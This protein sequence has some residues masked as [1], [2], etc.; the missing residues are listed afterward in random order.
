[1]II[2]ARNNLLIDINRM[3]INFKN[4]IIFIFAL[5]FFYGNIVFAE[6]PQDIYTEYLKGFSNMNT[7]QLKKKF[8]Y[9]ELVNNKIPQSIEF[10]TEAYCPF[11]DPQYS[12]VIPHD[13]DLVSCEQGEVGSH[14]GCSTCIM[15][16]IKLKVKGIDKFYQTSDIEYKEDDFESIIS[17]YGLNKSDFSTSNN[18]WYLNWDKNRNLSSDKKIISVT[19]EKWNHYITLDEK[20]YGPYQEIIN[21]TQDPNYPIIQY[22]YDNK[23]YVI[24][25]RIFGPYDT[26]MYAN[27]DDKGYLIFYRKD[28]QFY[29]DFNGKIITP[30][31]CYGMDVVYTQGKYIYDCVNGSAIRSIPNYG[32][33]IDNEFKMLGEFPDPNSNCGTSQIISINGELVVIFF[34]YHHYQHYVYYRDMVFGSYDFITQFAYKNDSLYFS[35]MKGNKHYL[36]I[37]KNLI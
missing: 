31:M 6:T 9:T 27:Y 37:I 19:Q 17:N 4:S 32:V 23:Y 30:K 13:F 18:Y 20:K 28:K 3:V 36:K 7:E 29:I 8:S 34:K 35:Y 33:Y 1:M 12:Y 2:L 22:R 21:R 24:M 11:T 25:G 14:G 26:I 10:W 16:K 15:S 5:L